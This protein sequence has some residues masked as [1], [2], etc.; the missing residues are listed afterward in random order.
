VVLLQLDTLPVV[1]VVADE[2]ILKDL[3]VMVVEDLV[4]DLQTNRL[5]E[6]LHQLVVEVVVDTIQDQLIILKVRLVVLVL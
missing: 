2:P 6:V 3:V 1:A 5:F 4:V